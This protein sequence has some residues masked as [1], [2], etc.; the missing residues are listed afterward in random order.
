MINRLKIFLTLKK[1]NWE[2]IS[3]YGPPTG[4]T[5][6][7]D[8]QTILLTRAIIFIRL[9]WTTA[10]KIKMYVIKNTIFTIFR[11]IIK[12]LSHLITF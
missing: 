11:F 2:N 7:R 9:Q 8:R 1:K 4:L 10:Y 5:I 12:I 6:T 3:L